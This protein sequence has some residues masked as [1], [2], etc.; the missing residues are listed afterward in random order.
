MPKSPDKVESRIQEALKKASCQTKPNI[1][2]LSRE[3][4]VPRK[5]LHKRFKGRP[6]RT[7]KI[8]RNKVLDDQ[9]EKAIICWI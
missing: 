1:S 4:D 5:Q 8:P 7:A 3:F 6:P 2:A 9:Q